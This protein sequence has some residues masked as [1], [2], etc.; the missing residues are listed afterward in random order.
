MKTKKLLTFCVAS[1]L[2]LTA[3]IAMGVDL[4]NGSM[5]SA[6][7]PG[8]STIALD[9]LYASMNIE[10]DAI[11]LYYKANQKCPAKDVFLKQTKAGSNVVDYIT[12]GD[13]CDVIGQFSSSAPGPLKNQMIRIVV[14]ISDVDSDIDF[15]F[16]QTVTTVDFVLNGTNP[17]FLA[18]PPSEFG[19]SD[20]LRASA[21]GNAI[22][23]TQSKAFNMTY[24][25]I[26]AYQ[27]ANTTATSSSSS[28]ASTS[29]GAQRNAHVQTVPGF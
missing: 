26:E 16:R 11:A 25:E 12:N 24:S 4:I 7:N 9:L 10:M 15:N 23:T 8:P 1:G 22:M 20:T 2:F 21:F 14:K 18:L 13:N 6:L 5:A 28:D 17:N 3:N 19:W 27:Q 29:G